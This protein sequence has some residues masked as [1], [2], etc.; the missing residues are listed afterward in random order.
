MSVLHTKTLHVPVSL[1]ANQTLGHHC[2]H[3]SISPT[4][5]STFP[6][7]VNSHKLT[8]PQKS[9]TFPLLRVSN[10]FSWHHNVPA[11]VEE[12]EITSFH[13]INI[14]LLMR[15]HYYLHKMLLCTC[16][17][18]R[19]L[20]AA[21]RETSSRRHRKQDGEEEQAESTYLLDNGCLGQFRSIWL[22][23]TIQCLRAGSVIGISVHGGAR[24]P[25]WS[26]SYRLT[27]NTAWAST[28]GCL[29]T[30]TDK[31]ELPITLLSIDRHRGG[32]GKN[33]V[34]WHFRASFFLPQ[35]PR[36]RKVLLQ[37]YQPKQSFPELIDFPW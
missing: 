11:D 9:T 12:T 36:L 14:D 20:V 28:R 25:E 15:D 3:T 4:L 8:P 26:G 10:K 5:H 27:S 7:P 32:V 30:R 34:F 23:F 35:P 29:V 17:E 24:R 13:M 6:H 19:G 16:V 21:T 22:G 18:A 33:T 37:S 1:P 31:T 2:P